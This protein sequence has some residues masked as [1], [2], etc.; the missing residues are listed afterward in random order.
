M[1]ITRALLLTA[2]AA[3]TLAG[4]ASAGRPGFAV[5]GWVV[6][7]NTV[8]K[9]APAGKPLPL[10]SLPLTLGY[11]WGQP[12]PRAVTTWTPLTLAQLPLSTSYLWAQP[13][14]APQ[15]VLHGQPWSL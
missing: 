15:H 6:P 3:L 1:R 12:T 11:A 9:T 14:T 8:A 5:H 7:G 10:S 4:A 2:A 13:G